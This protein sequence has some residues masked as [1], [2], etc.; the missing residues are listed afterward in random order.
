MIYVH[1][2]KGGFWFRVLGYGLNV[3]NRD[4]HEPIFSVRNGFVK[5]LR[6]GKYGIQVLKP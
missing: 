6:A 4:I 2:Y 5:E 1:R 3:I